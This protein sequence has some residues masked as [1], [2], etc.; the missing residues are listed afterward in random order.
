MCVR[1]YHWKPIE[2]LLKWI[3]DVNVTMSMW[4]KC[5]YVN[6]SQIFSKIAKKCLTLLSGNA[7]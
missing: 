4:C 1:Y 5:D 6:F 2:K 7:K 3:K